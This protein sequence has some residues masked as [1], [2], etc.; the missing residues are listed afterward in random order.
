MADKPNKFH[1]KMDIRNP[2]RVIGGTPDGKPIWIDV[3]ELIPTPEESE[4]RWANTLEGRKKTMIDKLA[5]LVLH[6]AALFIEQ[7]F[8]NIA[9]KRGRDLYSDNNSRGA[10]EYALENGIETIQDG[11]TTVVKVRGK[12]IRDMTAGITEPLREAVA[13]RVNELVKQLPAGISK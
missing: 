1:A 6:N 11:L 7:T 12:I 8:F 9:D 13:N 5:R 3:R 4:E 2:E 10:F